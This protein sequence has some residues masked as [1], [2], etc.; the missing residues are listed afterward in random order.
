MNCFNV[1]T[2]KTYFTKK[3]SS[4]GNFTLFYY[5]KYKFKLIIDKEKSE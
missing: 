4:L 1:L 3:D 2:T 5:I